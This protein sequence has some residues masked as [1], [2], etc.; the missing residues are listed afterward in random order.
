MKI[1]IFLWEKIEEILKKNFLLV[2]GIAFFSFIPYGINRYFWGKYSNLPIYLKTSKFLFS[3]L[4]FFMLVVGIGLVLAI[5]NKKIKDYILK[6]LF[7]VS[8]LLF[9]IEI[10]LIF[11]FKTLISLT[12]IQILLE[13]NKNEIIEFLQTYINLKILLVP[14]IFLPFYFIFKIIKKRIK[15]NL[16]KSNLFKFIFIIYPLVK[17]F[18]LTS[19][20]DIFNIARFYKS[21]RISYQNIKE[22]N[23]I[24]SKLDKNNINIIS[25][26]SEIKNII[27]V[28]GESTTR[29]HMSLYGYSLKT[30]PLLEKLEKNGNLYKFTD[31]ISPH[32]HTIPV[33]KKLLTFYNFESTEEW[34]TYNNIIDI[35]KLAGYKTYWFSN[36]ESSGIFG[37]VAVALGNRSD[38]VLF[39]NYQ[40]SS[41][42]ERKNSYDEEIVSKSIKYIDKNKSKN[43]II[44]HLMGTHSGYINRYPQNFEIFKN[45]NIKISSY[46]NA[47]LYNDYVIDKIISNFKNEE[48]IIMYVSDHGEEVYDFRNFAGHAEENGSRYMIEIPFLIY[49]SD[50]F[51]E[52]YPMTVKKIEKSLDKPYMSDDLIHTILDIADIKT[53]E[54]EKTRSVINDEFNFSRKRIFYEKDYETY[55]R[56]KN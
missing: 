31:T 55:W 41:E 25:N 43:F 7:F 46:D 5:L 28:I 14:I 23:E 36:Q 4:D 15:I 27:L 1:L 54:Y 16:F 29:N 48:S 40:D 53:S 42:S 44:Y 45:N 33:I 10:F 50:K 17:I 8:L 52:N 30:N 26:N 24:F 2:F 6:F 37:N 34:Y 47:I 21:A 12:T 19:D 35:M 32:A 22:Y 18:S 20:L 38:T 49:V 9:I 11:T 39:N 3:F 51:K 56:N 13:T